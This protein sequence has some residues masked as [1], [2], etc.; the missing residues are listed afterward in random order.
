MYN[1][2]MK[3]ILDKIYHFEFQMKTLE[4]LNMSSTLSS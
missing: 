3:M 2:D 4:L 1:I